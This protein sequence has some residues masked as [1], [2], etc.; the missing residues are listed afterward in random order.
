MRDMSAFPWLPFA[1]PGRQA[2]LPILLAADN[3]IDVVTL[4]TVLRDA[5]TAIGSLRSR[6]TMPLTCD[7]LP[8]DC[9]PGY[10]RAMRWT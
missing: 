4:A 5:P 8:A 3:R 6:S 9:V 1:A 2:T 7:N 10:N